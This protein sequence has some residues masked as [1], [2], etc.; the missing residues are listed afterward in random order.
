M[1]QLPRCFFKPSINEEVVYKDEFSE[2]WD[3]EKMLSGQPAFIHKEQA[4]ALEPKTLIINDFRLH[5]LSKKTSFL[6]LHD[7]FK[8]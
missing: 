6:I 5:L 4:K 7:I 3:I 1:S 8:A 2:S